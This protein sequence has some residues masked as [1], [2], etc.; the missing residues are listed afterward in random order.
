MTDR[1]VSFSAKVRHSIKT[2]ASDTN[3]LILPSAIAD[4]RHS[5]VPTGAR[6]GSDPA[7]SAR[8]L[9][10]FVSKVTLR[11]LSF[12]TLVAAVTALFPPHFFI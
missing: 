6:P 4:R 5:P 10:A 12:V 3:A 8:R 11:G 1:Y 7:G 2:E 9:Q